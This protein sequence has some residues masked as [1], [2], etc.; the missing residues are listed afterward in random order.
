[1]VQV[2]RDH[3]NAGIFEIVELDAVREKRGWFIGLGLVF[4]ALGIMAI[5]LP[6]IASLVTTIVVGWL[7]FLGGIVQ[8]VHAVQNRRWGGS[9]WAIVSAFVYVIAG[10]LVVAFPITGTL[11]LTLILAAFFVAQGILKIV[12]AVQHRT[13]RAWGWFLFDGILSLVLGLLV[14]LGWPSTA[15]WAIGVLVGIDLLFGGSSMLLIGL[16]TPPLTR[17]RARA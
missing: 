9:G 11:T 5:L 1:M 16:G 6:F 7:M 17:A 8:G 14:G 3:G 12:R 2:V 10:L 4:M 13:M 15:V